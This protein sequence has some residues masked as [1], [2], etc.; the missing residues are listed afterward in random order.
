MKQLLNEAQELIAA[1][2]YEE[3]VD[4][5]CRLGPPEGAEICELIARAYN[6]RNYARGDVYTARVFAEQAISHGSS[7]PEMQTIQSTRRPLKFPTMLRLGGRLLAL[8]SCL[9]RR[10]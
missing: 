2:Q 9:P 7:D 6:G 3:A 10:S 8:A 1:G 4:L 5:L